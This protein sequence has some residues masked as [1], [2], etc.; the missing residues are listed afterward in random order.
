MNDFIVRGL[1]P[2]IDPKDRT[3]LRSIDYGGFSSNSFSFNIVTSHEQALVWANHLNNLIRMSPTLLKAIT[4]NL[5]NI[6]VQLLTRV[7]EN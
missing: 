4:S 1:G 6:Q 3:I 7:S 5:H 2:V